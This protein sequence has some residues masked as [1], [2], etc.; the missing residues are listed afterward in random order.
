MCGLD[1]V[2]KVL[3][4]VVE[5]CHRFRVGDGGHLAQAGGV[6]RGQALQH[7]LKGLPD[8]R[9]APRS[10]NPETWI[11]CGQVWRFDHAIQGSQSAEHRESD[12]AKTLCGSPR[13]LDC[14]WHP[15]CALARDKLS[16]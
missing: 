7:V 8:L 14:R 12:N 10:T 13:M 11:K 6:D 3:D 15:L 1:E 5:H 9:R 2:P 4:T 16:Q